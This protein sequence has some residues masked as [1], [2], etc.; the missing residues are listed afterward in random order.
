MELGAIGAWGF[1]SCQVK[2]AMAFIMKFWSMSVDDT[3]CS[4]AALST[5]LIDILS[6]LDGLYDESNHNMVARSNTRIVL[7][8]IERN[9]K[10]VSFDTQTKVRGVTG[11]VSMPVDLLDDHSKGT[12]Q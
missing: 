7:A 4:R 11:E 5:D 1:D 10:S 8:K 12:I 2:R 6:S 3:G 9:Y